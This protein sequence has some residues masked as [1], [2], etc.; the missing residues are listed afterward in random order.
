MP[1][2][3]PARHLVDVES[4]R[5]E[6]EGFPAISLIAQLGCPF[7]CGFCGGRESPMLRNFRTRSSANIVAEIEHIWRTTGRTG[8]MFYDDELNVSKS[9]V[10][11][12]RLIAARQQQL[13]V[14]WRFRGFI[15]SQLFTDEQAEAMRAAGFR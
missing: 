4:Y 8:F 3:W 11:L 13:G 9:L 5:Y 1:W 14:E 12:M 15:K 10:E 2:P 7:N 6:I